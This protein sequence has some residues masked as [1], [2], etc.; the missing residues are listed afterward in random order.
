[1]VNARRFCDACSS[2]KVGQE[3]FLKGHFIE[4]GIHA[5]GSYGTT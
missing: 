5:A 3:V 2:Q 1:V 4:V